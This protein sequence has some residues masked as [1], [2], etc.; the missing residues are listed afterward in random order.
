MEQ[1]GHH[2]APLG[3]HTHAGP[4]SMNRTET[5]RGIETTI[6]IDDLSVDIER[7]CVSV[8]GVP[9]H[10]THTEYLIL[11][12]LLMRSTAVVRRDALLSVLRAHTAHM[13]SHS[14]DDHISRLQTRLGR[15]GS[16]IRTFKGIGYRFFS[17]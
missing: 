13:T 2:N 12:T 16:W 3:S 15:F 7:E 10:L 14:L 6:V 4:G 8:A 11:R 9:I 1:D 17:F 5:A